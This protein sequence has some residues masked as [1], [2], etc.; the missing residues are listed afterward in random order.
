MNYDSNLYPSPEE[1]R[2]IIYSNIGKINPILFDY[3]YNNE[4][5]K[6][7]FYFGEWEEFYNSIGFQILGELSTKIRIDRI[8]LDK[9]YK[10]LIIKRFIRKFRNH[11]LFKPGGKGYLDTRDHYRS[12]LINK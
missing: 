1:V 5:K 8:R 3:Y 11:I 12:L 10:I 4:V 2:D 9:L 6:Y 7:N